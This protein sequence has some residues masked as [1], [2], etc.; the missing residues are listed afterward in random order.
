MDSRLQNGPS[1]A[2][3]GITLIIITP[4]LYVLYVILSVQ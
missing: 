1:L 4:R 2:C 3:L